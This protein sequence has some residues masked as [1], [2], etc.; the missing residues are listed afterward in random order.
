MYV[1]W[2]KIANSISQKNT[3]NF[4]FKIDNFLTCYHIVE[5]TIKGHCA[6]FLRKVINLH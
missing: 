4:F 5:K 2:E 6:C 1:C 3:N